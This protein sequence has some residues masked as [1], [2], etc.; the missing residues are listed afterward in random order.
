MKMVTLVFRK[1]LGV[2]L[3][4]AVLAGNAVLAGTFGKVIPLPGHISEIVLDEPRSAIYAADFTAGQVDVVSTT[5]NR[6]VSSL[7]VGKAPSGLALSPDGQYLVVTN[8]QNSGVQTL[9]SVTVVNLNDLSRQNYAISNPPLAVAFGSDGAALII[10]TVD[11][12][13]FRPASGTFEVVTSI[14]SLGEALPVPTPTFPRQITQA[15]MTASGDGNYIFGLSESFVFVY[16]V[17]A[18]SAVLNV[19]LLSTLIHAL[20]PPLVTASF[21]GSYFMAGQ[22]LMDRQMRVMAEYTDTDL[23][24]PTI[25]GHGIDFGLKTVY[26]S[27]PQSVTTGSSSSSTTVNLPPALLFQDAD[28]LTVRDQLQLPERITG[29]IVIGG[30][31]RYLYAAS[32]SGLLYLPLT[33]LPTAPQV[34]PAAQELF[35]QF[36]FCQRTP[37]QQQLQING[38]GDF[39]L[40]TSL[41]GITFTPSQGTAPATVTVSVDFSAYATVQGTTH[42]QIIVS[43]QNGVNKLNPIELDINVK[44]QDQR[45]V[46]LP[47]PGKLVDVLGDPR[48]DQFYVLDQ[49]SN[50]V[51]VFGNADLRLLGT[52]RT[53]NKPN[54]MSFSADGRYLLVANSAGENLTVINLDTMQNEGYLFMPAGDNPVSVAAD[55]ATTLVAVRTPGGSGRLDQVQVPNGF[56][57]PLGPL[58][59]YQNV[60]HNN[61]AMVPLPNGSGIFIAEAD[62]NVLLWDAS[63]Q[64]V[65]L[66]RKPFTSLLGAI[67]AGPNALVVQDNVLNL[68]LVPQ[69]KFNDAPNLPAGFAFVGN[70]A[71]RTTSPGGLVTDTGTVQR[72]NTSTPTVHVSPVRLV[73]APLTTVTFPFI[74]SLA[75]LRNGNLISTSTTGIVQLPGNFDAGIA[76]PVVTA[77]TSAADFSNSLAPG[78]LVTIFGQNLASDTASAGSLPLPTELANVCV[79]MNGLRLPLLYTSPTQI[80]A[81]MPFELSGQASTVIHTQ[82]GKSDTYYAD[83]Q[84]AAPSIFQLRFSGQ[85][86]TFPAIVRARNGELATLSNPLHRN[87]YFLI[88]ATG[89]GQVG[90][91]VASGAPGPVSP[92]SYSM[93][94]PQVTVGGVPAGVYFSGLAPGF[95]GVYQLNVRVPGDAPTGTQ[96][97]LTV[98]AGGVTTT[99]NVRVVD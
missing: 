43:S 57:A 49:A 6:L 11:I 89:L 92:L 69:G 72:A 84:E 62:G 34:R 37:L 81:Q 99:V 12:E 83:L 42:G 67:A 66:A 22:Y 14:A 21:D 32:E 50:Q 76:V 74:R 19:R 27:Y 9:S 61:T 53:G 16:R 90:P 82:G 15:S 41:P 28:N 17:P 85:S 13:R 26:A 64:Q 33:D 46:L 40:S 3:A 97:P 59:V 86:G 96:I 44:D 23:S 68:S 56:T 77:I 45:G 48:R 18:P 20:A 79:T 70:T 75:G 87:D 54:W 98:T 47:V 36:D 7:N 93:Q 91:P 73:E 31:G 55:N 8:Y 58:G 1:S 65:V 29:R 5:S 39:S 25:G 10:T 95:V 80:N 35:F 52:F 4:L 38:T 30:A 78:G 88:F 2:S 60:V 71:V 94:T 24:Q 63:S 51:L